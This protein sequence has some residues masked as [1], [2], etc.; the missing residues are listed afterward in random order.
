MKRDEILNQYSQE[1]IE[2]CEC[3]GELSCITQTDCKPEYYT[4]VWF[5]CHC[6]CY[7]HFSLPVN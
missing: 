4:D 6:G 5:P 7:V 2:F 3:G 1:Y